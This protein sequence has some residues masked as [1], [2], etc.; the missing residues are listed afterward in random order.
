[1]DDILDKAP[2]QAPE[3]ERAILGAMLMDRESVWVAIGV[4]IQDSFYKPEHSVIFR[5]MSELYEAEDPVDQLSVAEKLKSS[6]KLDMVGGDVALSA[7]L[8]DAANFA[9]VEHYSKIIKKKA[10]LR[11]VIVITKAISAR[12][13]DSA[14]DPLSILNDCDKQLGKILTETSNHLNTRKVED[15]LPQV[16]ELIQTRADA[17]DG[18]AG[19]PTGFDMLDSAT[20]GW[21]NGNVII[22]G[23]KQKEGKSMLGMHFAING[24][25]NNAPTNMYSMEM[26]HIENVERMV[27]RE[28]GVDTSAVHR[29]QPSSL[30]WEKMSKGCATI[31]KWPLYIDTTP[32]LNIAELSAKVKSAVKK[33]GIKLVVVDYIQLMDGMGEK[34]RQSQVE[35]ISRGLK[36]LA[37]LVNIPIIVISQFSRGEKGEHRRPR[38]SDLRDCLA[39][40]TT[41]IYYSDTMEYACGYKRDVVSLNTHKGDTTMSNAE[42]I[43]RKRNTVYRVKTASG[44]FIDATAKQPVLTSDGFKKVSELKNTDSVA[45]AVDFGGWSGEKNIPEAKFIGWMLGNG[46]MN[47]Y[48]APSF[49]TNDKDVAKEFCSFVETKWGFTPKTHKH[50]CQKVFQYD[51]TYCSKRTSVP[52]KTKTWCIE[53]DLWGR[54]SYD[55][56]IPEWFMKKANKKSVIELLAGFWETDGSVEMGKHQRL[57]YSTAS[58]RIKE[59]ILY[60]LAKIGIFAYVDDGYLSSMATTKCYKITIESKE[61][62]DKFNNLITLTGYKGDRQRLLSKKCGGHFTNRVGQNTTVCADNFIHEHC[63]RRVARIQTHGGRRTT[64]D[65]L[66]KSL[67]AMKKHSGIKST[68]FDWLCSKHIVWDSIDDITNQGEQGVFD[69]TVE[70]THNFIANGIVVHNSGSLEQDANIILMLYKP[71]EKELQDNFPTVYRPEEIRIIIVGGGRNIPEQDIPVRWIP[72]YAMFTDF[73]E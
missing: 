20:A 16:M 19:I 53:N 3:I 64:K 61:F 21:Q 71:T 67:E 63:P 73:R 46:S 39:V 37:L 65:H 40:N 34:G 35:H 47:G 33:Y 17:V 1:M 32:G 2:P 69:L 43:P 22:V 41:Q 8:K 18:V 7:L 31:S 30:D 66:A 51:L 29:N 72:Q 54:K 42:F 14:A 55:K 48:P 27:A 56:Y 36:Q 49:I 23:A 59:Q 24:A 28:S 10:Q 58:I 57:S 62:V 38:L 70:N 12:C 50:K 60:L 44:R 68:P 6:G 11:R 52:N 45:I 25:I 13:M 4:G 5:A 15:V 9:T 26:T